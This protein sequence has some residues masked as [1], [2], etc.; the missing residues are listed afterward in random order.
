MGGRA[1][2]ESSLLR[3]PLTR[4]SPILAPCR[5]GR[6]AVR[7]HPHLSSQSL[8]PSPPCPLPSAG[9]WRRGGY[10]A[11]CRAAGAVSAAI[12]GRGRL[13]P[14][15]WERGR[16][17][18]FTLN[19]QKSPELEKC[20]IRHRSPAA[21]RCGRRSGL[22]GR[23]G[24]WTARDPGAPAP[25]GREARP[26]VRVQAGTLATRRRPPAALLWALPGAVWPWDL[27]NLPGCFSPRKFKTKDLASPPVAADLE[28]TSSP[29]RCLTCTLRTLGS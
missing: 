7:P 14:G 9:S 28:F 22:Q 2:A 10:R 8:S 20:S 18:R 11:G 6:S 1:P 23:Q 4:E 29:L 24:E 27:R 3:D 25:T 19:P 16:R 15:R 5:V 13:R 17:L 12:V 26:T 21:D